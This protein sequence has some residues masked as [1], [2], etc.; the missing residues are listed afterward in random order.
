VQ[1]RLAGS[2]G[3]HPASLR[4]R[5]YNDH[6]WIPALAPLCWLDGDNCKGGLC[7]VEDAPCGVVGASATTHLD[8]CG[9]EV[10]PEP[11]AS[12]PRP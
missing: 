4:V 12:N 10:L 5:R 8:V 6:V 1:L 2:D 3:W 11:S 9:S 7:A